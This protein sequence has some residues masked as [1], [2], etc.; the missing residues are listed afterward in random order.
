MSQVQKIIKYLALAFALF[1]I[2]SII[3]GIMYGI[4]F[5]GNIMDSESHDITDKLTNLEIGENTLLL[6]IN[7][8]S[9]NIIIQKGDTFKTETTNKYISSKQDKNK[10]YITERKHNW[11]FN[12]EHHEL[13]V[14]VP[15]DFVFDGIQITTGAG[16]VDI[17]TLTT[18][19][20]YLDLGAGK[21]EINHLTVLKSAEIEGGAGEMIIQSGKIQNLN[22]DM[23]VGRLSLTSKLTGKN[24]INSGIGE[25]N[26]SLVGS[27]DDYCVTLDK[28]I[29]SATI[30][31]TNMIDDTSY[32]IG[33]NILDIDGGIGSINIHYVED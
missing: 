26:L 5:F 4:S 27:K 30:D 9:S 6:D 29:G 15:D 10:L 24:K 21:V 25:L 19:E 12:N 33:N 1:L 2:F 17:E 13:I 16:K 20:L 3:S 31:G 23:G 14:Y 8:S 22:L 18:K 28:G 11:F 32:G 7:V